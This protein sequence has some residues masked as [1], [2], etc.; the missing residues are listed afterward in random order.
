[1]R[2]KKANVPS[3]DCPLCSGTAHATGKKQMKDGK[4]YLELECED[5]HH[6]FDAWKR[7]WEAP[8]AD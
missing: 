8:A 7:D 1:M 5:C 4:T 6:L 3:S 2:E